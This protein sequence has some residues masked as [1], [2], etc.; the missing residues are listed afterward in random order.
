M[1]KV[2]TKGVLKIR[3]LKALAVYIVFIVFFWCMFGYSVKGIVEHTALLTQYDKLY[4]IDFNAEMNYLMQ[5]LAVF[6]VSAIG[7]AVTLTDTMLHASNKQIQN[8]EI[9]D[10]QTLDNLRKEAEKEGIQIRTYDVI[11]DLVEDVK[12]AMEGL[13]EPETVEEFT[14]RGEVKKVFSISKVGKIAGVVIQEGYVEKSGFVKVYR[15][16]RKIFK[17]GIESLKHYKEDVLRVEAP[18]ECGIK[19][20]GFDDIQEGD[21]LEF[22]VHKKVKRELTFEESTEER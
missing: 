8:S 2:K 19:L 7:I 17:G 6:G 10:K 11:F 14:G 4:T 15:K 3:N 13:L 16:S 21:E 9:Q 1:L 12:L 18:Q 20:A 5:M 22:Y